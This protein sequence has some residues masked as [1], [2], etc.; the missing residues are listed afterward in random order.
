MHVFSLS[1]LI[2]FALVGAHVPKAFSLLYLALALTWV[3]SWRLDPMSLPPLPAGRLKA[4]R[5]V[6]ILVLLFSCFYPLAMLHFGFWQLSG[7]QL[8]DVVGAVVLPSGMLWWGFYWARRDLRVLVGCLLAYSIGGL[9]FLLAALTKTWG[10]SWFAPH[11]DPGTL[12]LAWGAEASMNVRSIEQ[13]GI[14]SV[15]LAPVALWLFARRRVLIAAVML[16]LAAL[17]LLAVLPLDHGRLW[18]V[19]LALAL[20]PWAY[21]A[22][23]SLWHRLDGIGLGLWQRMA[24]PLVTVVCSFV[25]LRHS[26]VRLCDERFGMYAQ[27]LHHWPQ[28]IAGGRVLKYEALQCDGLTRVVVSVNGSPLVANGIVTTVFVHSVPLDVVA[29]VGLW[30]ALPLLLTLG[31]ALFF[32][33]RFLFLWLGP[34]SL[35]W[36]SLWLHLFWCFLAVLV[37]QWLFQPLIYADGL[38]YY[39]SYAALGALIV[40]PVPVGIGSRRMG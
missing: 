1:L 3:M 14:L 2:L 23:V 13:N 10:L 29:A 24:L 19:S 9:V 5:V 21:R 16:L 25:A 11:A 30:A 31:I 8:L 18:I 6:Q 36:R 4:F 27:A 20:L 34:A 22:L 12:L 17:G 40:L 38:L 35:A 15:V 26:W 37:P 39:V 7:R 33:A 28:L 32:L